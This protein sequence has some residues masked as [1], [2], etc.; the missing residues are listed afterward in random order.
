MSH[1]KNSHSSP[2]SHGHGA[3]KRLGD[4]S[5]L[6]E[7]PDEGLGH[8]VP[9]RIYVKTL[10]T[11]LALTLITVAIAQVNFGE[12]NAIVALLVA[13]IKALLVALF[14]MHLKFEGRL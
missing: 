3:W 6:T 5:L 11:L 14:F 13:S 8:V 9:F 12:W 7:D 2:S 4:G 1:S 10:C